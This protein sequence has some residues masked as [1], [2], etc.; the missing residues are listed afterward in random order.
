M[1]ARRRASTTGVTYCVTNCHGVV[2]RVLQVTGVYK[3]LTGDR[4]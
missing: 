2:E 1:T 3:T 4:A